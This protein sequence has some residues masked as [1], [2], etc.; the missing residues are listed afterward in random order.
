MSAT[1]FQRKRR[2][3]VAAKKAALNKQADPES[4]KPKETKK[5]SKN[6]GTV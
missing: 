3:E 5:H 1:A 4:A 6:K 2:E